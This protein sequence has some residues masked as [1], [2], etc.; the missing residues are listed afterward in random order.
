[1]NI[2]VGVTGGIAAYKTAEL[3]R[4]LVKDGANVK[5]IMTKNA[6]QFITPVTLG[7]V[8]NNP[9]YTDTFQVT[10]EG[11]IAH[12]SIGQWADIL[13]IVPATANIIGKI[14]SGIADDLLTSTITAAKKPV[15]ICPA[16]N[17]NMYTNPFVDANLRKL[18][19]F[20]FLIME[21]D[22]GGLAC[23]TEG[24]G[25]LPPVE[26][27]V[28]EIRGILTKKDL[29]GFRILVTAGPTQE[30]LDPVRYITN[31]SSG[32]MGYALA[33]MAKR[34]G[35][36]VTLVSGPTT[37]DIPRGINLIQVQS[38]LQMRDAVMAH[39]SQVDVVIKSAAVSDYRPAS[40]SSSKIKKEK[41]P[42]SVSL[43][44]NPDI[45]SEIGKKKGNIVLVGFAMETDDLV[46]NA[47]KKMELKSMDLIV[48]N[49][50]NTP[51]SGFK[52]DTNIVT[53][54]A[55]SGAVEELPKMGK[56][57]VADKILDRVYELLQKKSL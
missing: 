56:N 11:E 26:D 13:V 34:R 48:A 36:E 51:G 31:H 57:E 33:V 52:S 3:V 41:G 12:I 25:R 29:R 46:D 47:K 18:S 20:G 54:I 1:M 6:Q 14:S 22:I 42:L 30:P 4:L 8:S 50:L 38:A 37:L 15:L 44:R 40:Y 45:I 53:L 39:L 19:S 17:T 16:M 24:P 5:V 9:V 32:K 2:A 21:P 28:E 7:T 49:D 27:I 43:E 35:A 10:E 55:R 23:K